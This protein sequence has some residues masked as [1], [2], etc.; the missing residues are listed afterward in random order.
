MYHVNKNNIRNNKK[1]IKL[2]VRSK[3]F[4]TPIRPRLSVFRS[5]KYTYGQIIDDSTGTTLVSAFSVVKQIHQN[6]DKMS[7]SFNVGKKI[8]ELAIEKGIK[9]VVFD[10]SSYLYHGRVSKLAEGARSAGLKF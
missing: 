5:N 4:G 1:R 7:A 6:N 9:S 8:G 2:R 3:V 10:R